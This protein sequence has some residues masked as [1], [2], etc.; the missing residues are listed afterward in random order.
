MNAKHESELG[1][2]LEPENKRDR[3]SLELVN[4]N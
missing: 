2:N 4:Y 3:I 1:G